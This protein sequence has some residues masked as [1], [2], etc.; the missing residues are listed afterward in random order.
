MRYTVR[1][2]VTI[3]TD[4]GVSNTAKTDTIGAQIGAAMLLGQPKTDSR[5]AGMKT[6]DEWKTT[7]LP[8]VVTGHRA[9]FMVFSPMLDS[10]DWPAAYLQYRGGIVVMNPFN[11]SKATVQRVKDELGVKVVMYWCDIAAVAIRTPKT[12]SA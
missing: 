9:F 10:P 3:K 8:S 4:S 7:P 1:V 12:L 6:D 2:A 11:T 5:T